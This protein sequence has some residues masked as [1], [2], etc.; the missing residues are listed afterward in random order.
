[1]ELRQQYTTSQ[2]IETGHNHPRSGINAEWSCMLMG[3][4]ALNDFTGRT[5]APENGYSVYPR[6]N[7]RLRGR[8]YASQQDMEIRPFVSMLQ[9][10]CLTVQLYI[11]I[12]HTLLTIPS[13]T[14]HL[15]GGFI[16]LQRITLPFL[17]LD[18]PTGTLCMKFREA[19]IIMPWTPE[20]GD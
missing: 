19:Y 12:L 9:V 5:V 16:L 17:V 3:A 2:F 13:L 8:Y 14:F 20:E 15:V 1:M 10:L 6:E 7:M 11:I 4:G 18:I